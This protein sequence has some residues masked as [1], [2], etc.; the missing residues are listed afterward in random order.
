M[1][2][3]AHYKNE[4]FLDSAIRIIAED[5]LG[6][7]TIAA[8][9]KGLNAPIGSVYHRFASRD[10]L[11]AELWLR[12]VELYQREFIKILKKDGLE[13]MLFGLRW[14][15]AHPYEARVMLLYR[16]DD[17]ISGEWPQELQKRAQCL[18]KELDE[19]IRLF[20]E[21]RFGSATQEFVDRILFTICD[22]PVG[23]F[24]RYLQRGDIIPES[25]GELFR[26]MYTAL[27]EK[28]T[29]VHNGNR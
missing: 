22:A 29:E 24:R 16:I 8:L 27:M 14:I 7:L 21:K 17:L 6:A 23:I 19:A 10:E 1:G 4:E 5:G 28:Q 13:A 25:V 15:R 20:A 3:R 11:L 2:R 12:I 18:A 26:E 9:A